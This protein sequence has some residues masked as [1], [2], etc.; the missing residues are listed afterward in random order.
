MIITINR[1]F[2]INRP[3]KKFLLKP[4]K[5]LIKES[6]GFALVHDANPPNVCYVSLTDDTVVWNNQKYRLK[7]WATRTSVCSFARTAHSFACSGLLAS[8]AASAA[9]TRSLACSWDSF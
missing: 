5:N 2:H 4:D 1:K 7:Y 3:E 9:L 6:M 8:L